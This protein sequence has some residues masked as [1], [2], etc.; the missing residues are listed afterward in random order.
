MWLSINYPSSQYDFLFTVTAIY[1]FCMIFPQNAKKYVLAIFVN[2][3]MV[4]YKSTTMVSRWKKI[5]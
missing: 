5:N 3:L 1:I 2:E 4:N